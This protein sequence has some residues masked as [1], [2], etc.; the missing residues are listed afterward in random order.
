M[1]SSE[2]SIQNERKSEMIMDV[3]TKAVK[4]A[5]KIYDGDS[6]THTPPRRTQNKRKKLAV[7]G[8]W[9]ASSKTGRKQVE[10]VIGVGVDNDGFRLVL[11][12]PTTKVFPICFTLGWN[13]ECRLTPNDCYF[14]K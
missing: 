12:N 14:F 13:L 8:D 7:L 6:W 11:F 4:V 9:H 2:Q 5:V 3:N 10:A 1:A